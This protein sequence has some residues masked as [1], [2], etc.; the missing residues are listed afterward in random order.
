M[1]VQ[2]LRN[3]HDAEPRRADAREALWDWSYIAGAIVSVAATLWLAAAV[4]A[5]A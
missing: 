5:S 3:E 2:P 1:T 4:W